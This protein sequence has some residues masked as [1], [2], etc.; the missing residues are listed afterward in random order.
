[1]FRIL[2]SAAREIRSAPAGSVLT[3]THTRDAKFNSEVIEKF[4]KFAKGNTPYVK[5]AALV[6]ISGLQ[7]VV[8]NGVA[9]FTGRKFPTFKSLE[10]TKKYLVS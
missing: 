3:L 10:E 6:G 4:K 1:M 7:G 5:K 8:L 9:L 2:D